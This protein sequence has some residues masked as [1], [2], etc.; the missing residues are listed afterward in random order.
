MNNAL[1]IYKVEPVA[2]SQN[3][4]QQSFN[5]INLPYGYCLL[6]S[7]ANNRQ[8]VPGPDVYGNGK[9]YTECVR[10]IIQ[11]KQVL[12][13]QNTKHVNNLDQFFFNGPQNPSGNNGNYK[14]SFGNIDLQTPRPPEPYSNY[15]IQ[16]A[17]QSLHAKP[18]LLISLFF[19]DSNLNHIRDT[20][21]RK[22]KE[23]TADSGVAG[24]NEGVTIK[25]P[26][27]DDLFYYMVNIYQSYKITNGSIC[28]V[29]LKKET[30]VKKELAKLNTN[31]LQ[32]YVSK[33]VSQI[34]M[35]IYYYL[36]ASQLPQQLALPTYTSTKGSRV[37]EYNS[38]FQSG[39]SIGVASYN[40]VGNVLT[41]DQQKL[42][43]I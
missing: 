15:Y 7:N 2:N 31:V 30:D 1:P 25:T 9:D 21:V 16:L 41:S 26:N 37:L 11:T 23:I 4:K 20:V 39:N 10:G 28:F 34:N 8:G 32:D 3:T 35:Y 43:N 33:L 42:R 38:G 36:D 27:M 5:A 6:S 19:S 14:D 18:D 22:V 24:N 17:A 12:K 29:N 13:D 40:E